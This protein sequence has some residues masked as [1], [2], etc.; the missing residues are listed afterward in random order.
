MKQ[1]SLWQIFAVF[2]KIGAFTIGGGYVMVPSIEAELRKRKW[3]PEAELPD[4][5]AI[6]QSAP[7]L[8]A[9]NMAIFTGY[10]LHGISG[11]IVAT[12]GSLIA[13]FFIILLL[14]MFLGHAAELPVVEKMLR[15]VRP[16]AV[17]I[18]AAYMVKL[19]QGNTRWW[20]WA[21]S[22]AT[23][24]GVSFL[25]ISPIYILLTFIAVAAAISHFRTR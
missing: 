13:P 23:L 16:V 9:V 14:A 5:V 17:A 24:G 1:I 3:I 4:I 22:L 6:S 19:L 21:V 2:C 11:S 20:Q 7:G 10:R 12:L 25:H 8:L 15:G 18:I